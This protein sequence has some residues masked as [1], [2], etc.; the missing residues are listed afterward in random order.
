MEERDE[1]LRVFK[2]GPADL[3]ANRQGRLSDRQRRRSTRHWLTG[4]VIGVLFTAL[5][6]AG[7]VNGFRN[8]QV[9]A[10][11][12]IIPGVFG[13]LAAAVTVFAGVVYKGSS[14]SPVKCITGTASIDVV[15]TY[16][17]GRIV[18]L[19]VADQ[20]YNLPTPP[21]EW[22]GAVPAYRRILT[23]QPYRVY[24]QGGGVVAMEPASQATPFSIGQDLTA[25]PMTV[26]GDTP[27]RMNAFGKACV[28]VGVA[29]GLAVGGGGV[30][31]IV[32]QLTGTPA[33][34]TVTDCV[35]DI[36]SRAGSYN[37]TGTWVVGGDLV[38]SGGH[39]DG[40]T[41]QGAN[42]GDVGKTIDVRLAGGAAYVESLVLPIILTAMGLLLAALAVFALIRAVRRSDGSR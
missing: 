18:K 19:K 17:G 34:A 40:G 41:I 3:D 12:W 23:D 25:Q 37:C 27:L 26:R 4:I 13:L 15:S 20:T 30:F 6:L 24:V 8:P 36:A 39:V 28:A 35:Q 33:K 1:L 2:I 38:F 9:A 5:A 31:L 14:T 10:V 21:R 29:V 7:S 22:L 11:N 16:R 32:V 42:L